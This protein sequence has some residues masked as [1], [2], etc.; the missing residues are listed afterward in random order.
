MMRTSNVRRIGILCLGVTVVCMAASLPTALCEASEAA[1]WPGFR[2]KDGVGRAGDLKP[3]LTWNGE[4]GTNIRW[5]TRIAKHGSNSPIIWD[6]KVFLTGGDFDSRHVY[7]LSVDDGEILWEHDVK[8]IDGSPSADEMPRVMAETGVAAPTMTT[9]GHFVAAI[10]ATGDLVCL[11]M[12]GK[13]VWAKNLGVPH[14]HYGHASSL[15]SDDRRL[16]VQYDQAEGARLIAYEFESGAI[17]WEVERGV[18][19]WAS[20]ILVDNNGRRELILVNSK[21]VDS[22][23]PDSGERH[24]RVECLSG[25]V[26]PSAAYSNGIVSVA[27]EYASAVAIDIKDRDYEPK[28]LWRWDKTLPDASSPLA[29]G[30]LLIMPSGFGTVT[31]LDLRTA[32]ILWEHDFDVGF[33][34]SPIL[35]GDRVY[36]LDYSGEMQVFKAGKTFEQIGTAEIGEDV[37]AT[38]A[39]VGDRILIR[40]VSTLFCVEAKNPSVLD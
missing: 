4:D 9:N 36:L 12:D 25:E 39:F 28:E 26:A 10:F 24:W 29:A 21:D 34:S 18:I 35:V 1:A 37:Y 16:Y 5:K 31:C 6:D 17:A 14:N 3:P 11:T 30:D 32:E 8:D 40:G 19:S 27:N 2:G 33:Y 7:C 23:D 15:I 20:P 22:Y 38:P 13:R